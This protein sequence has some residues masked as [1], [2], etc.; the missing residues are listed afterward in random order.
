M[1]KLHGKATWHD[2]IAVDNDA[3]EW[4]GHDCNKEYKDFF[5]EDQRKRK[6]ISV[7]GTA[8]F[9]GQTDDSRPEP[10]SATAAVVPSGKKKRFKSHCRY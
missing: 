4:P 6:G 3:G 2:H 9:Q 5:K 1:V 8:L 10:V 7:L